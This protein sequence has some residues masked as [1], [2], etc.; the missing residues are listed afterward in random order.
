MKQRWIIFALFAAITS[1]VVA[2]DDTGVVTYSYITH[3]GGSI[4]VEPEV[5]EFTF[6]VTAVPASGYEFVKWMD[7]TTD[8]PRIYTHIDDES[9]DSTLQAIFACTNDVHKKDGDVAVALL[10][11]ATP[12]FTLTATPH[13]DASF[14]QWDD[15]NTDKT[16]NYVE[17]DGQRTA[18]FVNNVGEACLFFDQHPGGVVSAEY[19]TGLTFEVTATPH[20]GYTFLMWSDENTNN[21]RTYTH[22]ADLSKDKTLHAVF[23][24]NNDIQK[25]NGHLEVTMADQTLPSF[26]LEAKP[27]TGSLFVQWEDASNNPYF[28]NYVESMGNKIAYFLNT[29]GVAS[30]QLITHPGGTMAVGHVTGLTYSVLATPADGYTFIGWSDGNTTN[31]RVYI[32]EPDEAKDST[33][34]AVF[35]KD[36]DVIR[37]GGTVQVSVVDKLA[38]TFN[39]AVSENAGYEFLMWNNGSKDMAIAY[40][41]A[42][43]QRFPYFV[44]TIGSVSIF[45]TQH[46][47]GVV[48]IEDGEELFEYSIT[49][50]PNEGYSFKSWSDGN[51]DNPRTYTHPQDITKDATLHAVFTHDKDI[52]Q[53]GGVTEVTITDAKTPAFTLKAV[54]DTCASFL[55]W[56]DNET[57]RLRTYT[58]ADGTKIP[59]FTFGDHY[60]QNEVTNDVGGIIKVDTLTC[61]YTITALPTAGY[62]FSEWE[63]HSTN[64]IRSIDYIESTYKAYFSQAA[65]KVGDV[66]YGT[67]AEAQSA[68]TSLSHPITLVS[69]VTDDIVASERITLDGQGYHVNNLIIQCAA[70]VNLMS[71][72][73]VN[74]L[75]LNATTGSSAQLSNHE[76]LTCSNA[77]IDIKLEANSSVASPDKWYAVCV[78]FEVDI[79]NGIA[80]ASGTGTHISKTDYLV[81]GYDGDLRSLTGNGWEMMVGGTMYP[82]KFYMIG[83]EGT[84]NTWRFTKKSGTSLCGSED[85]VLPAYPGS[86]ID[87]GWNAIGN[88]ILEYADVTIS[89]IPFVQVYDN[90]NSCY[91]PKLTNSTTFVVGAPFFAQVAQE[92]QMHLTAN[93]DAEGVLYAPR[94][95]THSNEYAE[96]RFSKDDAYD[97]IFVS[98]TEDAADTYVIG[99]DLVKLSFVYTVPQICM[100]NYGAMLCAQN[101][102]LRNGMAEIPLFMYAPSNGLYEISATSNRNIFLLYQGQ[103]VADLSIGSYSVNLARGMNTS[104]TLQVGERLVTTDNTNLNNNEP[105]AQKLLINERLYIIQNGHTFDALGNRVQQKYW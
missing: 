23:T 56:R 75:Y 3:P 81:W 41:E 6:R 39:L 35:T 89:N 44:N 16:I 31:P 94:R 64:P 99:K 12:S 69:D 48:T 79:E 21:P 29:A 13:A 15:A 105:S 40:A 85:V 50:T 63:D 66:Y 82:G 78:P 53:L 76:F 20:E 1:I 27:N 92:E 88:S 30:Y 32:Q 60:M 62:Y 52:A 37:D 45:F 49:A 95:T 5:A 80:R 104:Y 86:V 22:V 93:P 77:Y 97:A 91:I 34:H 84:E 24:L 73:T 87:G 10:N 96:I 57:E 9:Q 18:Y 74:H 43:G 90:A 26:N 42:D 58:E 2:G 33:L 4:L 72:L 25:E 17:Q 83:I 61:G 101:A 14:R 59:I 51:A 98:A 11:Y 67:F 46:P 102:P 103:P 7:G 47:G 55:V 36:A 68:A 54:E 28:T 100:V 19:V 70:S 65:F 8:N 38:P 71:A